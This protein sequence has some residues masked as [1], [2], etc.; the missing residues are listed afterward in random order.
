MKWRGRVKDISLGVNSFVV[1]NK[2][3]IAYAEVK[4]LRYFRSF[5]KV[6][7][8]IWGDEYFTEVEI[9]VRGHKKPIVISTNLMKTENSSDAV[10]EFFNEIASRTFETRL[11][12]YLSA[13][14][15]CHDDFDG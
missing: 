9:H 2:E 13:L 8:S 6:V 7:G 1:K 11:L 5:T 15:P 14:V 4:Y 10:G 3:D 12:Q